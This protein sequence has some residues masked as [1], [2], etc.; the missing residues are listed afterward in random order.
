MRVIAIDPGVD[1]G[2]AYGTIEDGAVD[3]KRHGWDPW[4]AFCLRF[5][6]RMQNFDQEG[7]DV[8]VMEDWRLTK[9]GPATLLG[10]D[11]PSSQALGAIRLAYDLARRAGHRVQLVTQMPATKNVVDGWMGGTGYLPS[12]DVDHN[13]DAVRHFWYY[14][15]NP[16]NK[17]GVT[18]A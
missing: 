16:K 9:R 7:C 11:L 3:I 5:Y 4:R 1:T 18:R 17:T 14:A 13:R 2:W 10:S 12:S 6:D 15:L 8:I